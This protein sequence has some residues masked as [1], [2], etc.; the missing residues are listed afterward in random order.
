M[1][2]SVTCADTDRS[3]A[4][5]S[6]VLRHPYLGLTVVALATVG[7]TGTRRGQRD[8]SRAAVDTAAREDGA[9]RA[10]VCGPASSMAP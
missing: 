1:W 7:A 3:M 8:V 6:R 5:R 2:H 9:I 10:T 4:A